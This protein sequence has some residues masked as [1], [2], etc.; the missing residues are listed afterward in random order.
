M[1][2][3]S[4]KMISRKKML[5]HSCKMISRKKLLHH[6][7]K[8]ISR[9]KMLHHSCKMISRKNSKMLHHSC[10]MISR[11]NSFC[12]SAK[13][14]LLWVLY[15]TE[16]LFHKQFGFPKLHTIITLHLTS[17][18]SSIPLFLFLF[19]YMYV[20]LITTAYRKLL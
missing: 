10:K 16:I 5:H 19:I 17:F 12:S 20:S 6:S 4:C 2:H 1:L 3:H 9:K 14:L 18:R 15:S 11:K 8:M 7:C 13:F